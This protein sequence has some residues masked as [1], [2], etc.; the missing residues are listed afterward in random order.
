MGE[1]RQLTFTAGWGNCSIDIDR[2]KAKLPPS[3]GPNFVPFEEPDCSCKKDGGRCNHKHCKCKN[4][5]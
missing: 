2:K 5:Q 1:K 3:S 4:R